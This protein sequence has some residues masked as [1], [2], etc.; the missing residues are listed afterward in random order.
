MTA[1]NYHMIILYTWAPRTPSTGLQLILLVL[2]ST[3]DIW[4]IPY[5]FNKFIDMT[6][7]DLDETWYMG[8]PTG[9]MLLAQ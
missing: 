7:S 8:S 9:H 4:V 3:V 5:H 6:L 2:G 1:G